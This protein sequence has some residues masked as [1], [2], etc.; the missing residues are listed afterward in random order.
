MCSLSYIAR[1]FAIFFFVF[2]L[3]D[4]QVILMYPIRSQWSAKIFHP[5]VDLQTFSDSYPYLLNLK[6]SFI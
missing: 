4:T 6:S 5:T 3:S 1:F 2:T